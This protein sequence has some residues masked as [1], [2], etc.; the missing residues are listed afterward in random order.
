MANYSFSIA[1]LSP[2]PNLAVGAGWS[3]AT[4]EPGEVGIEGDQGYGK[5]AIARWTVIPHDDF[6][7]DYLVGVSAWHIN[8][9][10]R[11]EF[12]VNNGAW[13]FVAAR[14]TNTQ[15]LG[16]LEF[17]ANIPIAAF[18]GNTTCVVR[19]IAYPRTAGLPRLLPDLTL[20]ARPAGIS[21]AVIYASQSGSNGGDGSLGNPYGAELDYPIDAAADGGIVRMLNA[22]V[23]VLNTTA[24]SNRANTRWITVEG[25]S[26]LAVTDCEIHIK[27]GNVGGAIQLRDK[28][29]WS[30][31][32]WQY[33]SDVTA[34]GPG[35]DSNGFGG[36]YS[37]M[38]AG[39][40]IWLDTGRTTYDDWAW[41]PGWISTVNLYT[42]HADAR[43]YATN[44]TAYDG[45]CGF[46]GWTMT[47]HC[48]V[49]RVSWRPTFYNTINIGLRIYDMNGDAGLSVAFHRDVLHT[50]GAGGDL[51]IID[52]DTK[53]MTGCED[54]T[55]LRFTT[56][57][58]P[59][60][61]NIAIVD[62]DASSLAPVAGGGY[63]NWG[64]PPSSEWE[65]TGSVAHN[66][67]LMIRCKTPTQ[68]FAFTGLEADEILWE[69]CEVHWAN[70]NLLNDPDPGFVLHN[71]YA[72]AQE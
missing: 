12:S 38:T 68:R 18:G 28:L 37:L 9:I 47:R 65:S 3:G 32:T 42:P 8:N 11:V 50:Y 66:H 20:Y 30:N 51:N 62:F 57:S 43:A 63:N 17:V 16:P 4:S 44:S 31:C 45:L 10:D 61:G 56:D 39:Q 25:A 23:Y 34:S 5:K 2:V 36:Q 7:A 1:P 6:A 67:I 71:T 24:K 52:V 33:N 60:L 59:G 14:R 72:P 64:N 13:S 40:E 19:A 26:G 48:T 15:T 54:T 53:L 21:R 46:T 70:A 69:S 55:L 41:A 49:S 29:R 35:G 58:E 22:G 27:A